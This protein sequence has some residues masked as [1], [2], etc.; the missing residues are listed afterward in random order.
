VV[1]YGLIYAPVNILSLNVS[2]RIGQLFHLRGK[3]KGG[4]GH[5]MGCFFLL[6]ELTPYFEEFIGVTGQPKSVVALLLP[7]TT[8]LDGQYYLK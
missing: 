7:H 8:L 4:G 2:E 6:D 5:T 3:D 1:N